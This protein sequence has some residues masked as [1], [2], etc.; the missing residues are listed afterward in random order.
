[1]A[2][3]NPDALAPMM[4][5]SVVMDSADMVQASEEVSG[6]NGIYL[7]TLP[8]KHTEGH[9]N[10]PAKAVFSSVFFR[11]FPCASVADYTFILMAQIK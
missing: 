7:R 2:H 9:G 4:R 10:I 8:R 3:I 5:T 1:M 6:M 11:V